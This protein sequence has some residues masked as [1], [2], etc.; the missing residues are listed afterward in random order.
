M[1]TQ[2]R[3]LRHIP[4]GILYVY[5]PAFANR[6]D[7]EEII[8]VEAKVID[9]P[10]PKARKKKEAAAPEQTDVDAALNSALGD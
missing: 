10:A 2:E 6:P 5:Q 7:F 8:N 9:E 4:T 1:S 3:L